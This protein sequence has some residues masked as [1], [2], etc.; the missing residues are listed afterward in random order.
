MAIIAEKQ[1]SNLPSSRMLKLVIGWYRNPMSFFSLL[2]IYIVTIN[3]IALDR[4]IFAFVSFSQHVA[5]MACSSVVI[6]SQ[7]EFCLVCLI[8]NTSTIVELHTIQY[9]HFQLLKNDFS[10][11]IWDWPRMC[12]FNHYCIYTQYEYHRHFSQLF[13]VLFHFPS[14][15]LHGEF[16][17]KEPCPCTSFNFKTSQ[18]YNSMSGLLCLVCILYIVKQNHKRAKHGCS[19]SLWYFKSHN[20]KT[21]MLQICTQGSF[22]NFVDTKR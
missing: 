17:W 11:H 18:V 8:C 4:K 13:L 21:G 9:A 12:I 1:K 14:N 2:Y 16:Q 5:P 19:P 22:N 3:K 15:S 20:M 7:K 6:T 10:T